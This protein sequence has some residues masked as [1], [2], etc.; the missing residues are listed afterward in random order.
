[1]IAIALAGDPELLIAD[2]PT[3][4]LDVT[5]QAQ[6]LDLLRRLQRETGMAIFLITHDLGVVSEMTDRVA[7]MYAGQVVELADRHEFFS[8]PHHPYS[9]KLF[10][11]LAQHGEADPYPGGHTR[12]PCQRSPRH[13][14]PAVSN[15]AVIT[16]GR[17]APKSSRAGRVLAAEQ[18]VRCHLHDPRYAER[19]RAHS[20]ASRRRRGAGAA[21]R[22]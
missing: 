22:P 10:E 21:E 8:N 19:R 20:H 4:A 13:S 16:L 12:A 9:R 2:E 7:V 18:G 3:T 6:V 11:S 14:A 15:R 1:M 17:R 5:I